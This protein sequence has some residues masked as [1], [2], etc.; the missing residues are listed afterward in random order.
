[1][2]VAFL[3]QATDD[4]EGENPEARVH[5]TGEH[6]SEDNKFNILMSKISDKLKQRDWQIGQVVNKH[7][8]CTDRN[9]VCAVGELDQSPSHQVVQG[10]LREV[11]PLSI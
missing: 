5:P 6:Y 9:I 3:N 2:V 1:M 8:C 10:I 11:F 4:V 7:D